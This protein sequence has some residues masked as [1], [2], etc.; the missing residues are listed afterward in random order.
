MRI[1]LD[2]IYVHMIFVRFVFKQME[3]NPFEKGGWLCILLLIL[4]ISVLS[5]Q[6]SI[7]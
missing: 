7:C 6:L 1:V 2:L 5:W 3:I 4:V